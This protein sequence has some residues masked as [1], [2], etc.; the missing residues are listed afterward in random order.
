MKKTLLFIFFNIILIFAGTKVSALDLS[1][2]S[3]VLYEPITKRF[4]YEKNAEIVRPLASTTKIV[5][6]ITALENGNLDDMVTVSKKAADTEGSSIWLSEG[7]NISLKDLIYGM[8]LASG[9]DAAVAIS[10]HIA[11]DTDKF[12]VLMN[13][14]AKKVGATSSN[15]TNP[16]GLDIGNHVTTAKDLA[17]ITAYALENE[18]FR[19]IVAT[20]SYVIPWQGHEWDRNIKNHNKL[21]WNYEGCIGVKTGFT[22]KAG[23]CLVSAAQRD[24]VVLIAVTLNAPNDWDDHTKLFDYGFSQL[25]LK[26]VVQK[27]SV[28][29]EI[30]VLNGEK[31]KVNC[32]LSEDYVVPATDNDIISIKNVLNQNITAPVSKKNIAGFTEV[33]LN[34]SK[35][36]EI[37]IIVTESVNIKYVPTIQDYLYIFIKNL[38]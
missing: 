13:N 18:T 22:K 19:K 37:P 25:K 27:G 30:S 6:A 5:T 33:Y 8:M 28:V 29:G 15:F 11:G 16:S 34:N 24:G 2:Q 17:K 3:A 31:N 1:A 20:K 12:S 10:E 26:K 32:V 38:L 14:I 4:F 7:E 21:L 9:N 36:D 35:I 23:R